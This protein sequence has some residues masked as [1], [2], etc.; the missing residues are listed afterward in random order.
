M[1]RSFVL[2][3]M[4]SAI[5]ACSAAPP[6]GV[7]EPGATESTTEAL[8]P[9]PDRTLWRGFRCVGGNCD[10]FLTIDQGEIIRAGYTVDGPVGQCWSTNDGSRVNL[11]R[12]F[13]PSTGDH[14]YSMQRLP[15]GPGW[16]AEGTTCFVYPTASIGG[17]RPLWRMYNNCT[18]EH[19]YTKNFSEY[20]NLCH[21]PNGSNCPWFCESGEGFPPPFPTCF[22][23]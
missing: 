15:P 18:S 19:M 10:H 6:D 21:P 17:V 7:T 9:A 11:F 14:F 5:A 8:A 2:F 22:I 23:F 16:Q 4:S 3:A 20:Q 1:K 12:F 13:F